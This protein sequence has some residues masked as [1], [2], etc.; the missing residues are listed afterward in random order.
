VTKNEP[1]VRRADSPSTGTSARRAVLAYTSSRLGLFLL[2]ALLLWLV[3][4]RA[5][6]LVVLALL[7]SGLASYAL[8]GHQRDAVSV[9]VSAAMARRRAR[10]AQ[11][12]AREDAYA[13]ELAARESAT[14]GGERPAVPGAR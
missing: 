11:R 7:I 10:A 8:L 3:R 14:D 9:H 5:E 1:D 2:A 6:L 12:V 13:D 4:V